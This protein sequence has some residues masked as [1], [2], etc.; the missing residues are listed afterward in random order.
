[1]AERLLA[2]INGIGSVLVLDPPANPAFGASGPDEAIAEALRADWQRVGCDIVDAAGI[3][4]PEV[5]RDEEAQE[6]R[7]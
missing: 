2:F 6:I 1:M 3:L 7:L 4:R 5:A